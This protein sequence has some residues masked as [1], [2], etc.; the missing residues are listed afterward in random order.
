MTR[1]KTLQEVIMEMAVKI[2]TED[3]RKHERANIEVMKA[4]KAQALARYRDRK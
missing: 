1:M 4:L 3:P 2:A